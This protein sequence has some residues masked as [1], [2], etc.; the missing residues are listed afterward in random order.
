[1]GKNSFVWMNGNITNSVNANVSLLSHSFSRGSAIFEAFGVH[2][3]P[4]GP[5]V[6]RMDQ[7]LNRLEKSADL[8]GMELKYS[9]KEIADAVSETVKINQTKRGLIKIMAYWGEEA[10]VNM[11]P[12][13]K[14]DVAV[15]SIN[16]NPE[17]PL[18]DAYPLK[19]CLSK[20]RKLDPSTVPVEA[21]VVGNY[22]NGYLARKEA[23]DRGFDLSFMLDTDGYLAEGSIESLFIVKN[24]ILE[25]PKMGNILSSISRMTVIEIAKNLGIEVKEKNIIKEDLYD[26]QEIFTSHT[27]VK[28]HPVKT[29]EEYELIAPGPITT[30]ISFLLNEIINFKNDMFKNYFQDLF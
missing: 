18:D 1:M 23:K 17:L 12:D 22:L 13:S 14:L 7:H 2:E 6:F 20:W 26:A 30:K 25:T 5:K 21:K 24:E 9:V 10:V 19:T 15:F 29:F 8:L 3:S 28:V 27:G 16:K 11:V 4:N